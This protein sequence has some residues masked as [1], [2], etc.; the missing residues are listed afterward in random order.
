MF[1]LGLVG[2]RYGSGAPTGIIRL[3]LNTC[4]REALLSREQVMFKPL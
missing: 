4:V 3:L 2:G 1:H